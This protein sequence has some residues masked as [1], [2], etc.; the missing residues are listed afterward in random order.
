MK[1]SNKDKEKK[2]ERL[3]YDI[4][5]KATNISALSSSKIDKFECLTGEKILPPV[6]K[7]ITEKSKFDC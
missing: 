5:R 6:Q 7:E 2:N 3:Q 1:Y 4:N